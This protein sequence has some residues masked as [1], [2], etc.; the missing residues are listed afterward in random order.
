MKKKR[1]M[2]MKMM[3]LMEIRMKR[4]MEMKGRVSSY[5]WC[6]GHLKH[7]ST[8]YLSPKY[9]VFVLYERQ[10]LD[11]LSCCVGSKT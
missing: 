4:L 7:S 8:K 11:R 5:H 6:A 10:N 1:L 3:R 9:H 2:E